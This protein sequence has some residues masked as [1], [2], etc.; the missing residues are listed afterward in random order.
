M[1]YIVKG[2]SGIQ[3]TLLQPVQPPIEVFP[4]SVIEQDKQY[5]IED[6]IAAAYKHFGGGPSAQHVYTNGL[7]NYYFLTGDKNAKKGTIEIAKFVSKSVQGPNRP[8][9][10]LKKII[11]NTLNWV[12]DRSG[13]ESNRP[14]SLAE[15][16]DRGS[17]NALNIL[18]DAFILE[19]KDHYLKLAEVLIR[20]CVHPNDDL[21]VRNLLEINTRWSYTIFFQGIGKFLD[22]KSERQEFDDIFF[23]ARDAL[24]HYAGWMIKHEVPIMTLS[25]AFDF[26]NHATRAAND[27]RKANVLFIASKYAPEDKK[28]MYQNKA[29]YF[30]K[31]ACNGLIEHDTSTLTRPLAILMQNI[32][33][34]FQLMTDSNQ[35]SES[36]KAQMDYGKPMNRRSIGWLV[37]ENFNL[38]VRLIRSE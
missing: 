23:Y 7:T 38:L 14:Y 28:A 11:R 24:F 31:I 26:P 32:N 33:T 21:R 18:V 37:K 12:K 5:T 17:G 34:A 35:K 19:K 27:I 3:T 20:K 6:G 8:I 29:V 13:S 1:I 36:N 22:L 30:F 10:V 16:P 2:C 15:G 9:P 4:K 25:D